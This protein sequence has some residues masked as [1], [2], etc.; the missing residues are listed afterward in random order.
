MPG[1]GSY[2]RTYSQT[3]SFQI[4]QFQPRISHFQ[5]QATNLQTSMYDPHFQTEATNFELSNH[6]RSNSKDIVF[7]Q[8]KLKVTG[9][10]YIMPSSTVCRF[11]NRR[12]QQRNRLTYPTERGCGTYWSSLGICSQELQKVE[13]LLFFYTRGNFRTPAFT[14]FTYIGALRVRDH[15]QLSASHSVGEVLI[16]QCSI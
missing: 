9:S 7:P 14:N 4:S 6:K 13:H 5:T 11:G 12:V 8:N 16:T 2:F 10:Q 15:L 3:T 1:K